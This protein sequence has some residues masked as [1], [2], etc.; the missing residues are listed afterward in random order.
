M[1]CERFSAF[2]HLPPLFSLNI[3]LLSLLTKNT[4]Q[5]FWLKSSN[6]SAQNLTGLPKST[7]DILCLL[8]FTY[9]CRFP[10]YFSVSHIEWKIQLHFVQNF[11]ILMLWI[12]F[13]SQTKVTFPSEPEFLHRGTCCAGVLSKEQSLLKY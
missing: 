8:H 9:K 4:K 11:W 10:P 7:A 1:T 12:L 13:Q 2:P 6:T 5:Y 3:Y